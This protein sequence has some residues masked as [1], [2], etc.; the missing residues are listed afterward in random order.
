[1]LQNSI[2]TVKELNEKIQELVAG[3]P[4]LGNLGVEGEISGLGRDKRGHMYFSLKDPSGVLSAVMFAGKQTYGLKFEPKNGD[5]V[6]AFGHIDVFVR[7]GKY[8]LYVDRLVRVGEGEVNARL[9]KLI[10]RLDSMGL[11]SEEYKKPIP[12]YPR[13]IGIVTAGAKAAISDIKAVAKR[14][15]PYAQLICYPATVQGQYAAA[16]ISRGIEV[17]DS[18]GLDVI[19]VGRG[20]GSKE[21]LWAFNE[22]QVAW[23]I[24]NAET[25][26][27][28][29]TGHEIDN[30]V[31]DMVADRRESNPSTA[32]M[33]ALPV[34]ADTV[35]EL[36]GR[37]QYLTALMKNRYA[38]MARAVDGYERQIKLLGPE[39]RLTSQ[40]EKIK[41]I[42]ELMNRTLKDKLQVTADR[43]NQ[44]GDRIERA[45]VRKYELR[46]N[47][48]AV[49]TE[50]IHGL[51]P[52]AKLING[53]GYMESDGKPV[54]S[55]HDVRP[56]SDIELTLHDG[57][58][59]AVVSNAA[60]QE[61]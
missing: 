61:E 20:G 21:D 14:R 28:T 19:I 40:L 56:G 44:D 45:V 6:H 7:D 35:A 60:G 32:V 5:K 58:I 59:Q 9:E 51:S 12:P 16:D 24:F 18:M 57:K 15:D 2:Y 30:T 49:M 4:W 47:A 1:M 50:R 31:A 26:I 11:F 3:E 10:A 54:R 55:V 27:I 37:C 48:L 42:E 22:E 41:D 17:L 34:V 13:K 8:Q 38:A 43:L 23:A 36:D 33:H 39:A 52:T 25:P 46:S 53:F 29:A